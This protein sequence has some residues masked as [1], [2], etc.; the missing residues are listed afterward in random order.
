MER[1]W[2]PP[3]PSVGPRRPLPLSFS[4]FS[5]R[6][7]AHTCDGQVVLQ[8]HRHLL[9]DEGLEV[10]VEQHFL[11]AR[12]AA[13]GRQRK[14]AGV[15]GRSQ[16]RCHSLSLSHAGEG[17][18]RVRGRQRCGEARRARRHTQR[19]AEKTT[20]E[21]EKRKK[22]EE[23]DAQSTECQRSAASFFFHT[24]NFFPG[25]RPPPATSP[26]PGYASR[27]EVQGHPV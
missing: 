1:G 22:E 9:A 25:P 16:A 26:P 12:E 7:P 8:L 14:R 6:I 20:P 11:S 24:F 17:V 21:E 5:P 27:Y 15:R 19:G 23:N 10:G 3:P 4:L 2:R 13:R 18:E